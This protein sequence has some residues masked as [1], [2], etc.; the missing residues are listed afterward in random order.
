MNKKLLALLSLFLSATC[1]AQNTTL[2]CIWDTAG[3]KKQ[4]YIIEYDGQSN[5]VAF[6]GVAASEP[7][8]SQDFVKF[9]L[10]FKDAYWTHSIRRADGIMTV[11][12]SE[13][14]DTIQMQC[15]KLQTSNL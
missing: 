1:F 10:K 15:G 8:I 7:V 9:V 2:I 12:K 4:S 13:S 14:P 5:T 11:T 6:N 3:G